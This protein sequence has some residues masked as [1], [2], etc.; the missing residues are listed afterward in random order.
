MTEID[1]AIDGD[2]NEKGLNPND[3]SKLARKV[4]FRTV[5]ICERGLQ[6]N[7]PAVMRSAPSE[8]DPIVAPPRLDTVT[9]IDS[10]QAWDG[11]ALV[12]FRPTLGNISLKYFHVSRMR[13]ALLEQLLIQLDLYGDTKKIYSDRADTD[14]LVK[15]KVIEF[16]NKPLLYTH[17]MLGKIA[18]QDK[19]SPRQGQADFLDTQIMDIL[20]DEYLPDLAAMFPGAV[21]L[22]KHED[23]NVLM[24]PEFH[25]AVKSFV[26][27]NK[28]KIGDV[29]GR[30][31]LRKEFPKEGIVYVISLHFDE[32]R[33]S[34]AEFLQEKDGV[35]RGDACNY[36][37]SA[38]FNM[39]Y[40]W[41]LDSL[42][43][44]V[45][46][47]VQIKDDSVNAYLRKAKKTRASEET[48]LS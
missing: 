4:L 25:E 35:W 32:G 40:D 29:D 39:D 6:N 26:D 47:G 27:V 12:L 11:H 48:A 2:P 9:W 23:E 46:R 30:I 24:S 31:N 44:V 1:R 8:A 15:D 28:Q 20:E 14:E 36:D 41:D 18:R 34:L 17:A 16:G 5:E 13:N 21:D 43:R 19:N 22:G 7:V 45:Y 38:D 10:E 42:I 33:L 37:G 3:T